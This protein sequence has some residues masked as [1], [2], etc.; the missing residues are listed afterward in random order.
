M[1]KNEHG[2]DRELVELA[3]LQC[4]TEGLFVADKT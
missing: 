4:E 3:D 1:L 2:E